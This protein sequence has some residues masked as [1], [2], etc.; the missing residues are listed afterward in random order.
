MRALIRW[1]CAVAIVIGW[2]LAL[3]WILLSVSQIAVQRVV[4]VQTCAV[5]DPG[6]IAC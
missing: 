3:L 5:A 6:E 2:F 4:V 1:I